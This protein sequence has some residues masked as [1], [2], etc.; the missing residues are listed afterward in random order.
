MRIALVAHAFPPD[1]VAGVEVCA[2]RHA[3]ALQEL[4]HDV[5]VVTAVRDLRAATGS[6]RRRDGIGVDVVEVVNNH[7]GGGLASTYECPPVEAAALKALR[8]H[9]PELVHFHHLLNLSAGLLP[10]VRALGARTALTLHDYWLSCARDGQRQ[11]AD[12]ATCDRVEAATCA[13]CLASS[14]QL[15]AP[16]ERRA[17]SAAAAVGLGGLLQAAHRRFPRLGAA[18]L[19][20]LRSPAPPRVTADDVERRATMLRAAFSAADVRVAPTRFAAQRAAEAGLTGEVHVLPNGAVETEPVP[21]VPRRRRTI[22]F[23]GT[24]AP[25]K[26]AHVLLEAFRGLRDPDARLVLRGSGLTAPVYAA[27]LARA[28][29]ADPRVRLGGPFAPDDADRAFAELDLLALPS[30]WW[31]NAPLVAQEALARG[32]PVLASAVGGVPEVVGEPW[33]R[34]LPPG[35]V[36]AWRAA[37]AEAFAGRVFAEPLPPAPVW[38]ATRAARALLELCR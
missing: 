17:L 6:V 32:I 18:V 3:R 23:I 10:A 24:L 29:G 7:D 26:G 22:G 2:L 16:V 8:G 15:A 12:F 13:R 4:G 36:V 30:L 21:F 20:A 14:P 38:T 11:R 35:D 28:A 27:E 19:A 31:E 5:Q 1:S 37:L 33:G 9:A 34:C 25:H